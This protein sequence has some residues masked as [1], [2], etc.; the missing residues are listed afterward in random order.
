M[1]TR[2]GLIIICALI[3]VLAAA[4]MLSACASG[5]FSGMCAVQPVGQT[6]GGVAVVRVYCEPE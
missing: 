5:P 1:S 6:D 3:A 4:T 2:A